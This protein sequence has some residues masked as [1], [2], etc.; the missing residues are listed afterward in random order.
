MNR[1]RQPNWDE[2]IRDWVQSCR[3]LN[4]RFEAEWFAGPTRRVGSLHYSF[5]DPLVLYSGKKPLA[6]WQGGMYSQSLALSESS[7][8]DEL[9][10]MRYPTRS[11]HAIRT[12]SFLHKARIKVLIVDDP[13]C[14]DHAKNLHRFRWDAEWYA[15]GIVSARTQVLWRKRGLEDVEKNRLFYCERFGLTPM[16]LLDA[17]LRDQMTAKLIGCALEGVK[18]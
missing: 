9:V 3:R 17:E 1:R 6:K 11:L 18:T 13:L 8:P 7:P 16:P 15:K 4:E 2:L 5:D 12:K 10:T 14:V